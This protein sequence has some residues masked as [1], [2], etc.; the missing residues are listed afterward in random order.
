MHNFNIRLRFFQSKLGRK[1]FTVFVCCA[2]LPLLI[3]SS[4]TYILVARQIEDQARKEL[5]QATKSFGLTIYD[6][7]L[8]VEAQL[9]LLAVSAQNPS[10][11]PDKLSVMPDGS[12]G[13]N[14]NAIALIKPQTTPKVILGKMKSVPAF[15]TELWSHLSNG[16]SA[17][18]TEPNVGAEGSRVY[19]VRAI[20]YQD[21]NDGVLLAEI[22]PKY[23][24]SLGDANP[25]PPMTDFCVIDDQNTILMT[26]ISFLDPKLKQL[27]SINKGTIFKSQKTDLEINNFLVC[28]WTLFLKANF[29]T[30]GWKIILTQSDAEFFQPVYEFRFAFLLSILLTFW[31]ILLISI[32]YIRKTLIPMEKLKMGTQRILKGEFDTPVDHYSKDE[33]DDLIYSFNQ[34]SFELGR[35]VRA[36]K[37]I[38]QIGR[39]TSGILDPKKLLEVELAIMEKELKFKRVLVCLADSDRQYLYCTAWF[40]W[41]TSADKRLTITCMTI[42]IEAENDVI[43][44]AFH[45]KKAVFWQRPDTE[46]SLSETDRLFCELTEAKA[47]FCAPIIYENQALGLL[48]VESQDHQALTESEQQLIK[49]I[50]AQTASGIYNGVYFKKLQHSE[51][52]FRTVFDNTAAGMCLM[53]ASGNIIKSNNRLGEILGY[54]TDRLKGKNWQNIS[55]PEDIEKTKKLIESLTSGLSMTELYEKRFIHQDG[56][57]VPTLVSTSLVKDEFGQP[58]YYISQIQDLSKQKAAESEKKKIEHQ[59]MQSQKMEAM[60]TLAGGIAHDFNNIISAIMGQVELGQLQVN[61][62]AKVKERFDGVLQAAQRAK[63]LVQQIL[64]FSRRS[65]QKKQVTNVTILVKETLDLLRASLPANIVIQSDLGC[66]KSNI[67]ADPNQIHQVIMNLGT[68]AYHA[69][70]DEGGILCVRCESICMDG[71]DS[72]GCPDLKKGKYVRVSISDTGYGISAENIK[73]IFDPYFTTK[74]KGKGTGLGLALVHGII[75]EHQ[76]SIS[77]KSQIGEGTSFEILLPRL[78]GKAVSKDTASKSLESGKERILFVDDETIIIELGTD[79]LTHLGYQ[80]ESF[81]NPLKALSLLKSEPNRYDLVITDFNMPEMNGDVLAQ[82][83][84]KVKPDLPVILCSG[85][86]EWSNPKENFPLVLKA[87]LHKPFTLS[88][89][90]KTIRKVLT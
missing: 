27:L 3:L 81:Q 22:K 70:A 89:L 67:L 34:M 35:Q 84:E 52:R 10:S 7:L 1:L 46:S 4:L 48:M 29:Y 30:P 40:G 8:L 19:L 82:E 56:R 54:E 63:A 21:Q 44:K 69:M 13:A 66:K 36:L 32:H 71:S 23:I 37:V 26:T 64:T 57:I 58:M 43:A 76:G 50:A 62:V 80:V 17:V 6:R 65:D 38:A 47:L 33:F 83:I 16:R 59:L 88:E 5:Q 14:L 31:V 61:E 25:L 79:M 55:H 12:F 9:Q 73:R 51:E 90:T 87:V 11:I 75:K 77:V 39:E 49:G 85:Y 86:Q 42:N 45:D 74:K 68:N 78:E 2:I 20:S 28:G 60:G 41:N 72:D 53:D 15:P 24:W 18:I